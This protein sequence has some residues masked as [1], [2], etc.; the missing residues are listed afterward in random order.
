MITE[1]ITLKFIPQRDYLCVAYSIRLLCEFKNKNYLAKIIFPP[2]IYLLRS[3]PSIDRC[4]MALRGSH[5]Y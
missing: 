2:D 5:P 4:G 3:R 1:V